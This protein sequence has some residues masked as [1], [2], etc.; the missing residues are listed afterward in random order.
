MLVDTEDQDEWRK[1]T[2]VA[3]PSPEAEQEKTG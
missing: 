3:D 2:L 1:R